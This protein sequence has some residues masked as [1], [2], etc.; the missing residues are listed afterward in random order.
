MSYNSGG[1]YEY[2]FYALKN[3]CFAEYEIID[4][5]TGIRKCLGIFTVTDYGFKEH[6]YFANYSTTNNT[7]P[8]DD[9]ILTRTWF[10]N[11]VRY[12]DLFETRGTS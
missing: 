12:V 6:Y 2:W 4:Q 1:Y 5:N 7:A 11:G 8:D 9:G 10:T 3:E